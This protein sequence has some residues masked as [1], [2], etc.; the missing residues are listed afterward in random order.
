MIP[1]IAIA[2]LLINGA[3]AHN[4]VYEKFKYFECLPENHHLFEDEWRFHEFITNNIIPNADNE[5]Q[6]GW[7]RFKNN[8]FR[9]L[10]REELFQKPVARNRVSIP[11]TSSHQHGAYLKEGI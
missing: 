6:T 4:K 3:T 2:I 1:V 11:H 9:M 5:L 7:Y 8:S 10:E